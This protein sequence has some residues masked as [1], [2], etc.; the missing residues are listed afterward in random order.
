MPST[1]VRAHRDVKGVAWARSDGLGWLAGGASL[2]TEATEISSLAGSPGRRRSWTVS[3]VEELDRQ[4]VRASRSARH[5]GQYQGA[6]VLTGFGLRLRQVAQRY[7][8]PFTAVFGRSRLPESGTLLG[9]GFSSFTFLNVS[10]GLRT[11]S[12]QAAALL[13]LTQAAHPQ[14][15]L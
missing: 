3:T 7:R 15:R 14:A 4:G 2:E 13:L 10:S 5:F 6:G 8:L 11:G 12:S 1:L 9:M